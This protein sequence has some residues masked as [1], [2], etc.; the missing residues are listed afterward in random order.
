MYVYDDF[1]NQ[2]TEIINRQ[3]MLLAG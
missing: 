3:D 2:Y 1:F